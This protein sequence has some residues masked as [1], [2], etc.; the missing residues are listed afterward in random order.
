MSVSRTYTEGVKTGNNSA[1]RWT[2]PKIGA[3]PLVGSIVISV[4]SFSLIFLAIAHFT[5]A[6][7]RFEEKP[8]A[9]LLPMVS[10]LTLP[11]SQW[12]RSRRRRLMV[13]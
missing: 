7:L 3:M 1:R 8:W 11:L 5:P 6:F 4:F 13:K 9:R 12:M 10:I 2:T